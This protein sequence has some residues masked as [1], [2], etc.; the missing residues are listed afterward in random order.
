MLV[1]FPLGLLTSA[2]PWP[3]GAGRSRSGPAAL[4]RLAA[5]RHRQVLAVRGGHGPAFAPALIGLSGLL[6]VAPW[7]VR[8]LA[9]LDTIVARRLLEGPRRSTLAKVTALETSRAAAVDSAESERR[10]IERDLHDGAQQRLVPWPWTSGRPRAAGGRPRGRA[11]AGRRGPRGGQGR[12]PGDPRPG[13]RHPPRDPRGPRPRRRPVRGGGPLAGPGRARRRRRRAAAGGGR[14]AYFV[15]TEA[16]TNV[17]RHA[18]ATE[19]AVAIVRAGDRLVVEVRDD[20]VGGADPGQG[21]GLARPAPP[22][23]PAGWRLDVSAP[24][25]APRPCWWSCRCVDRDRR[26]LGAAARA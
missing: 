1:A 19:A 17:A 22:G 26:G 18:Q 2:W 20:G 15:V 8:G 5:R 25:A 14:A 4:R 23:R 12:P 9:G 6:V 3:P 16:L 7:L 24:R 13:A 21:T 11:P 10:R